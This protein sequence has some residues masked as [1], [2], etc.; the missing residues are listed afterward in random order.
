MDEQ[1]V[2]SRAVVLAQQAMKRLQREG[3]P[4]A[5]QLV[6]AVISAE[7]GLI[8]G[9]GLSFD[10]VRFIKRLEQLPDTNW[11]DSIPRL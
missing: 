3:H 6:S 9:H 10:E 1:D 8:L 7:E 5:C 4:N 11:S 2:F